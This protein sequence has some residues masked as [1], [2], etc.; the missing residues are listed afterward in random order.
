MDEL[1]SL[2]KQRDE[3]LADLREGYDA[4]WT[5][6]LSLEI[7]RHTEFLHIPVKNKD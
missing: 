5:D 1:E 6:E 4:D 7:F 3:L 2:M